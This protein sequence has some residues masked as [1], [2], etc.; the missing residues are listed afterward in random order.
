MPVG[1]IH[2]LPGQLFFRGR[3]AVL[4]VAGGNEGFI[5]RVLLNGAVVGNVAGI[6][7]FFHFHHVSSAHPQVPGYGVHLVLVHPAQ[8]LFSGAKVKEEFALG[9]GRRNLD[10]APVAQDEFVDLRADPVHGE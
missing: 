9:L 10:N 5:L 3:A 8:A 7:A 4:Q 2:L 1:L 6:Q